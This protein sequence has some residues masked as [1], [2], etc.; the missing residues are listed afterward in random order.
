[1]S[2]LLGDSQGHAR[3]GRSPLTEGARPDWRSAETSLELVALA[4]AGGAG[5]PLSKKGVLSGTVHSAP[6]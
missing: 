2:A 6:V 1:M 5:M 4:G 3:R